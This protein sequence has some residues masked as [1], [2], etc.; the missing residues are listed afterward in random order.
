MKTYL[1]CYPCYLRQALSAARRAGA[2][3]EQQHDLL[4]WTMAHLNTLPITAT[5]P[6]M[7][8]AIHGRV[9]AETGIED[10]Y[11]AAKREA[12]AQA[13]ARLPALREIVRAAAD[14]L[15]TAVRIAIAGNII[16]LGVSEH[17]DLDATLERVLVEPFAIDALSALRTALEATGSVLYLGDNAGETVFDRVLIESLVHGGHAVTYVV[18]AA[19]IINDATRADALEAGLGA[20]AEIIDNGTAAPGTLLSQGSAA[21][22]E[23]F[24]RAPLIL[25]KG[26]ANYESLSDVRAPIFFLLQ[27]KCSVIAD[28][29]G[30]QPGAIILKG[31]AY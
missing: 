28:D 13:L 7:A 9:R 26:Q 17:F 15:A 19:P 6:E 4:L 24:E 21:F 20:F 1:D 18:K 27:A 25:A 10:P 16:D 8:A 14:P 23:R 11:Q 12:T 5:P 29:L 3:V 2:T 31:S 22:R 30:V